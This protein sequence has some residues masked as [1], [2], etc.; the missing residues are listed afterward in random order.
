MRIGFLAPKGEFS[1]SIL[2]GLKRKLVD[3]TWTQWQ[4]DTIP[5]ASNIEVLLALGLV[6]RS[7]ME[8]LPD[9]A[10]IQMLSDGYEGV[11]ID[12]ATDLGIRVSYSPGD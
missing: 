12:A 1:E 8:A 2:D 3:D 9:L 6:S 7:L 5:S 10:F 4:P 11:D